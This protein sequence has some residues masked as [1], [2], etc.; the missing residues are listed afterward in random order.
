MAA[1]TKVK[2]SFIVLDIKQYRQRPKCSHDK[3]L[4]KSNKYHP[5][6]IDRL[7]IAAYI[8]LIYI[9]IYVYNTLRD[10]IVI[11]RVIQRFNCIRVS[12]QRNILYYLFTALLWCFMPTYY[13]I[14]FPAHSACAV[15]LVT[16]FCKRDNLESRT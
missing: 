5:N 6:F 13:N 12:R 14:I 1:M 11:S 7:N 16:Y 3:Y 15:G 9:Y 4:Y 8:Y 10:P 2:L